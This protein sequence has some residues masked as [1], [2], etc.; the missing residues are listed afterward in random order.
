MNDKD[1][2][3]DDLESNHQR[4]RINSKAKGNRIENSLCK[5][6][7]EHFDAPFSRSLGSGARTSQVR[8]PEYAKKALTGDI[9]VPEKFK[10]VIECKGGYE[11]DINLNNVDSIAK[12]DEFIEQAER[13]SDYCGRKPVIFWKRNRK[14]WLSVLPMKEIE[15]KLSQFDI[16]Y[17]YK[18]W[19]IVDM[20]NLFALTSRDF[21]FHS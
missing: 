14:P 18:G 6:L 9:C 15:D 16:Y 5:I 20:N 19:V 17:V 12:L 7:S 13:D 4:Q 3:V 2:F 8:L 10:W 11:D 21:W 1:F